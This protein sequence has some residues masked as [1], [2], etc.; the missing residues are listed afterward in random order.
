M[1]GPDRGDPVV[2]EKERV[3]RAGKPVGKAFLT[4]AVL[5]VLTT[6][7]PRSFFT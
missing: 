5:V 4:A 6:Y 7:S 3:M 2:A 1:S